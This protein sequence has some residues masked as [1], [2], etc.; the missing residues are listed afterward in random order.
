LA[1]GVVS[2]RFTLL[3]THLNLGAVL[4]RDEH[5]ELPGSLILEGPAAWTVRPVFE[6][7]TEF[8]TPDR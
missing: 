3:T 4:S 1:T 7:F 5:L 6:L 2:R 8:R